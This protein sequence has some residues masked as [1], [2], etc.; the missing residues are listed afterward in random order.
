MRQTKHSSHRES[1]IAGIAGD[2]TTREAEIEQQI[3]KLEAMSLVQL[4]EAWLERFG[5]QAPKLKGRELLIRVLAFRIQADVVGDHSPAVKRKLT[6]L[7]SSLAKD[8]KAPL[9]PT[10]SLR[11]GI[12]LTREWKGVVHKVLV[13]HQGFLYA[14]KSYGSLSDVARSITGTRWSGPR[15]FGIEQRV[16]QQLRARASNQ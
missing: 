2:L 3:A 9:F 5:A 6:H 1:G 12:V 14:D 15:F 10:P 8:P 13:R 16:R 7:A 4:R 11:P